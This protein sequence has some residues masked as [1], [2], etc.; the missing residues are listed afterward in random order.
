MENNLNY[1]FTTTSH[2]NEAIISKSY[3]FIFDKMTSDGTAKIFKCRHFKTGCKTRMRYE[4]NS[5]ITYGQEHNHESDLE[6]IINQKAKLK[7]KRRLNANPTTS[8][9]RIYDEVI[10]E[11]RN[12]LKHHLNQSHL[13]LS[14]PKFDDIILSLHN[15]KRLHFPK[16]PSSCVEL[17]LPNECTK[18]NDESFLL[19]ND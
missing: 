13:S 9:K 2:G 5:A 15:V 4:N 19:L 16:Q 1:E 18:I 11:E 7:I 6:H 17:K 3:Y 12:I 8:S 14:L 10:N